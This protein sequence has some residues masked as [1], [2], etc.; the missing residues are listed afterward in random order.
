MG[1]KKLILK[2]ILCAGAAISIAYVFCPIIS[3]LGESLSMWTLLTSGEVGEIFEWVVD[4]EVLAVLI[5]IVIFWMP[6]ILL[7]ASVILLFIAN[8]IKIS[9]VIA[10]IGALDFLI[11]DI[12]MI[13]KEF[14]YSGLFMNLTGVVLIIIAS[15]M[16][17][18]EILKNHEEVSDLK[19]ENDLACGKI[20]CLAGEYAGG[21][22]DIKDTIVIGRD[23]ARS[24]IILRNKNVSRVHCI[25]KYVQETDT[26]TV[27]DT[28]SNGTYYSDGQRLVRGFEMQVP[29]GTE[30]Y[31]GEPKEIFRLD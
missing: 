27:K 6:A 20:I 10:L 26:Y 23:S 9:I 12:F 7:I 16:L 15:I 18:K 31:M 2:I 3:F 14:I 22:F 29:R 30:I 1:N 24:N 19:Y 25:I 11:V 21:E 8:K 13:A 5:P 28:S 17:Y 4:S